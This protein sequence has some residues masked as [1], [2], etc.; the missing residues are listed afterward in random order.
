LQFIAKFVTPAKAKNQQDPVKINQDR[1]PE[2]KKDV[3]ISA[4]KDRPIIWDLSHPYFNNVNQFFSFFCL[5]GTNGLFLSM[6]A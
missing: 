6:T 3:L 2:E 4:I 5:L 1:I